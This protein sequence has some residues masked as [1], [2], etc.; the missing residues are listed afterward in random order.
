MS[1]VRLATPGDAQELWRLTLMAHKENALRS[2]ALDR[3][4]WMMNRVLYPELIPPGD[5]GPRGI[6]GVIGPE[7]AIKALAVMIIGQFWYTHDKH[8]EELIV[9]CDPRYRREHENGQ[10]HIG[11]LV[12]W[13]RDQ[14]DHTGLPLLTGIMSNDRVEA[15][16]RL[17]RKL[18]G[19]P[20]GAFFF[21]TPKGT[22]LPLAVATSS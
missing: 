8:L 14:A 7:G 19:N 20:I 10:Y 17:Y 9:Y 15:K 13:M 2:L 6:I 3:I 18:L 11:A 5:M 4:Q 16:V 1:S 12:Q 22:S 21:V